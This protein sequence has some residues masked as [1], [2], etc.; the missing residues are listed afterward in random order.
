MNAEAVLE[1]WRDEESICSEDGD[2]RIAD[3][4]DNS[5]SE[6]ET[7][8][9]NDIEM[10]VRNTNVCNSGSSEPQSQSSSCIWEDTEGMF[11]LF[12]MLKS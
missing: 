1:R 10:G 12:L 2:D 4:D 8:T 7:S 9:C 5:C 3:E 11:K 6:E